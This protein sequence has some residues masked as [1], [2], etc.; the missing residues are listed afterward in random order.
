METTSLTAPEPKAD[1]EYEA[2]I[3]GLIAQ[4]RRLRT[5]MADDQ[6]EIEKLRA[7]TRAQLRLIK[8]G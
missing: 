2:A 8:T 7:E 3:D 1:A 4:M 6:R 5:E